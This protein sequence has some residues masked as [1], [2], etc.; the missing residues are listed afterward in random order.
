VENGRLLLI[1][2]GQGLLTRQEFAYPAEVRIVGRIVSFATRLPIPKHEPSPSRTAHNDMPLSLP[3]EHRS[4]SALLRAERLRFDITETHLNR[5]ADVLEEQLGVRLS[6][7]TLR[8]Y[9]HN[10]QQLPRT[11]ILLAIMAVYS[12]RASDVLR[13][14][15]LWPAGARKLSLTTMMRA[16]K[17]AEL[18]SVFDPAP[19]P[20]P[21]AQWQELLEQ[22]GEWPRLLSMTVPYLASQQD[23]LLRLNRISR[24]RGLDPLVGGG[25]VVLFDDRDISPPR[26]GSLERDGWNRPIYVLRYS[27]EASCGYLEASATHFALQPH[28]ASGVPRLIFPHGQVQISGR[29]TAVA[30]PL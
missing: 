27:G 20:E 2:E 22:W 4:F 5:V 17:T 28:P 9:E 29:V 13:L 21:A 15:Q 30:S 24:F 23:S 12:L 14:L 26:N 19:M 18:P 8:R 7:R 16:S 1:T 6:A 3:W 10:A 25:S 11:A